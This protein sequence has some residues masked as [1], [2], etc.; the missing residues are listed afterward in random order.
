MCSTIYFNKRALLVNPTSN[1]SFP[2]IF[3]TVFPESRIENNL[4]RLQGGDEIRKGTPGFAFTDLD[5]FM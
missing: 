3:K 2:K 4:Q 5:Q 1:K